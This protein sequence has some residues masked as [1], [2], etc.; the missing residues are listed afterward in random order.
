MSPPPTSIDGTEIT[1]ATIDGQDV[2][3]ITIDG[4]TVFSAVPDSGISRY[5]F[6]D[7]DISSSTLTDRF[8][9]NDLSLNGVTTGVSGANET[10]NTKQAGRFDGTDDFGTSSAPDPTNN[11]FSLALWANPDNASASDERIVFKGNEQFGVQVNNNDFRGVVRYADNSSA[12]IVD[13]GISVSNGQWF[14]VILAYDG[15]EARI[16]VDGVKRDTTVDGNGVRTSG[17]SFEVGRRADGIL[18]Y[19]GDIDDVRYYNKGLTDTEASNLYNTG[20][21]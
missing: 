12:V 14:H 21:I 3:E 10:Y 13:A 7:E 5:T 6:N 1:G 15:S 18:H 8:G 9:S 17:G 19:D 11:T 4:Q 20:S 2:G 16:Y